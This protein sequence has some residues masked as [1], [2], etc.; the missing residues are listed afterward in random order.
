G[1]AAGPPLSRAEDRESPGAGEPQRRLD[2]ARSVQ[3]STVQRNRCGGPSAAV[4]LGAVEGGLPG[5]RGSPVGA[6]GPGGGRRARRAAPGGADRASASMV[7]RDQ[8]LGRGPRPPFVSR[9]TNQGLPSGDVLTAVDEKCQQPSWGDGQ[10][11]I[12]PR[13][14][15]ACSQD[16]PGILPW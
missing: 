9:G 3:M 11:W 2:D 14:R 16:W 10:D 1:R 4:V 15:V 6:R 12:P 13:L 7:A 8:F 5:G